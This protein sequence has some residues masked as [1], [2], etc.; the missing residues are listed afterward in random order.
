MTRYHRL[1]K[2]K[3]KG[4]SF[5]I[6][7]YFTLLC[8][9][10]LHNFY[11]YIN[12]KEY[13]LLYLNSTAKQHSSDG[14]GLNKLHE[15]W[16]IQI[17]RGEDFWQIKKER[18]AGFYAAEHPWSYFLLSAQHE[19]ML[20]CALGE[21]LTPQSALHS[22]FSLYIGF[23]FVSA[24]NVLWRFFSFWSCSVKYLDWWLCFIYAVFK[25]EV[26]FVCFVP[27]CVLY[28]SLLMS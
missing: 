14:R 9:M 24:E 23:I 13:K 27:R 1:Y 17:W 21:C 10:F 4:K 3:K 7:N 18:A 16:F 11:L 20:C 22:V 5:C 28:A 19:A 2:K 15:I 25:S 12:I 8:I 6:R 26:V